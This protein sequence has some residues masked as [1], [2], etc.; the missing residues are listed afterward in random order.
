M[1]G[2][3][4]ATHLGPAKQVYCRRFEESIAFCANAFSSTSDLTL[5]ICHVKVGY[6]IS[7]FFVLIFRFLQLSF[8]NLHCHKKMVDGHIHKK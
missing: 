5:G 7:V 3:E 4:F 1:G 6:S 2:I 8:V